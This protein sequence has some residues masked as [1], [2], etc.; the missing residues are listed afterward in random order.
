MSEVTIERSTEE[1][2][3]EFNKAGGEFLKFKNGLS[4]NEKKR[5]EDWLRLQRE[6][7]VFNR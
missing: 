4:E 2:I 5:F 6:T 3:S 7:S 1:I